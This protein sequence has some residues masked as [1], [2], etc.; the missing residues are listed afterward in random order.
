MISLGSQIYG[1]IFTKCDFNDCVF[2]NVEF[3]STQF[4][5]SC[6]FNNCS[7]T[8]TDIADIKKVVGIPEQPDKIIGEDD[9]SQPTTDEYQ[10]ILNSFFAS[11]DFLKVFAPVENVQN[12]WKFTEIESD[13][14]RL[15]V[16]EPEFDENTYT[17][18]IGRLIFT[19]PEDETKPSMNDFYNRMGTG[20]NPVE[21]TIELGIVDSPYDS[22]NVSVE[23]VEKT[24]W[25]ELYFNVRRIF[26][27]VTVAKNNSGNRTKLE[28]ENEGVLSE[29]V[30]KL[31]ELSRN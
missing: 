13:T 18:P 27:R 25:R 4:D 23:T 22:L 15:E 30:N 19:I 6:I 29:I 8:G 5:K 7:F 28:E 17:V 24:F 3:S 31:D 12:T 10:Q 1:T 20:E 11:E 26:D 21:F 14:L 2:D 9:S 16:S